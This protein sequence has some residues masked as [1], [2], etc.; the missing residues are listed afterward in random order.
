MFFIYAQTITQVEDLYQEAL[1][2]DSKAVKKD[3]L[4]A[5]AG[6]GFSMFTMFFLYFCGFAGGAY[7]MRNYGYTF[8]VTDSDSDSAFVLTRP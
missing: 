6:Q 3:A 4:G 1:G 5:G 2:K 8:Q 7:L